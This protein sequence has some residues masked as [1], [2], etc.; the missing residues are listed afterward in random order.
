MCLFHE[1]YSRWCSVFGLSSFLYTRLQ[2]LNFGLKALFLWMEF[3]PKISKL[4][5]ARRLCFRTGAWLSFER[6]PSSLS[7]P[8]SAPQTETTS[9]SHFWDRCPKLLTPAVRRK[10]EIHE[11]M[12]LLH[13]TRIAWQSTSRLHWWFCLNLEF[14]CGSH[15]KIHR[16]ISVLSQLELGY[17]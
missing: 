12:E 14:L 9:W 17:L 1:F 6:Y 3:H 5:N 16:K 4:T 8:G 13:G 15:G 10:R 7:T 11:G 2:N